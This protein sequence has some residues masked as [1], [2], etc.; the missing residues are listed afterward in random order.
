M[1][2]RRVA[3]K[4]GKSRKRRTATAPAPLKK[5]HPKD[6]GA[7]KFFVSVFATILAFSIAAAL[8]VPAAASIHT[9]VIASNTLAGQKLSV[10]KSVASAAITRDKFDIGHL[11]RD[12]GP[13]IGSSNGWA[14]PTTLKITSPWGDRPVICTSGVG[15]D[16]GFHHGDDFAGAC[17]TPFYAAS[18]GTVSSITYDGLAGDEIVIDYGQDGISTAYSHMFD[19]GIFV[20]VGQKVLAGDN[21][22]AMGST[23]DS[24]GCHLYFEYR[25]DN[26]T[27]DPVPAMAEHGITLNQG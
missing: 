8:A 14:L 18:G 1:A 6:S 27:V 21:I 2:G 5:T 12:G 9:G 20:Q 3:E 19:D 15:C 26:V 16:S 24:T 4:A 22:G 10:S 25:I 17:N 11:Y 23:G 13:A 7:R